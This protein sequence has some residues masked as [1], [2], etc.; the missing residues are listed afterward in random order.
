MNEYFIIPYNGGKMPSKFTSSFGKFYRESTENFFL[1]YYVIAL[2]VNSDDKVKENSLNELIE[3]MRQ[4]TTEE[5][6]NHVK[7]GLIK[8]VGL[9]LFNSDMYERILC[10][11]SFTRVVD[12]FLCY[13]KDVLSEI[14][15]VYPDILKSKDTEK[16]EDI[17]QFDEMVDLREFII[18]K[19]IKELFYKN[20]DDIKKFFLDRLNLDLFQDKASY[21]DTIVKQRNL[22]IH[23]R[24]IVSSEFNKHYP[25]YKIGIQIYFD[26]ADIDKVI[27][28]V[29]NIVTDIDIMIAQ[30][31]TKL[32]LTKNS[33]PTS[34]KN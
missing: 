4:H 12:N 16:L 7:E 17:L 2:D 13:I 29:G 10:Q 33:L 26:Y 20:I 8:E 24:G 28:E 9:A 18:E 3:D 21:I 15:K 32:K 5:I 1:I 11:M 31:Y 34:G 19:K 14:I 23:N 22:I 6:F 27:L 30:K 25:D